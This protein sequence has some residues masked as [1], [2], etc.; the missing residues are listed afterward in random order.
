MALQ[1][2]D[3][4]LVTIDQDPIYTDKK[5]TFG[6]L[7][8]ELGVQLAVQETTTQNGLVVD[9]TP[10]LMY[11]DG[12]FD[13]DKS[14]GRLSVPVDARGVA[15]VGL[16]DSTNVDS[17]P[18]GNEKS[19]DFYIC[20]EADL[21]ISTSK[22][23]GIQSDGGGVT[24]NPDDQVLTDGGL[25]YY[26]NNGTVT[27]T[28]IK[29]GTNPNIDTGVINIT[30]ENGRVIN[31]VHQPTNIDI[32][33]LNLDGGIYG[34]VDNNTFD[35]DVE[36]AVEVLSVSTDSNTGE[37][38]INF[39]IVSQGQG[40]R[41]KVNDGALNGALAV[42][43]NGDEAS[44]FKVDLVVSGGSV[45]S[46]SSLTLGPGHDEDDEFEIALP[47]N[48]APD[49]AAEFTL[50]LEGEGTVTIQINDKLIKRGDGNWDILTDQLANQAVLTI[51][52]EE[53][54]NGNDLTPALKIKRT[55]GDPRYITLA[56]D[57]V[58][59]SNPGLMPPDLLD[60][61]NNLP[62]PEF[63][64]GGSIVDLETEAEDGIDLMIDGSVYNSK[65]VN[66]VQVED[67]Q[68]TDD[69]DNLL[70]VEL[71]KNVKV[72]VNATQILTLG[73]DSTRIRGTVF[74]ANEE[75]LEGA[76]A[77]SD[78]D[79]GLYYYDRVINAAE[80]GHH[81]MPRNLE[82]LS[83][84]G[85]EFKT[86][87][88]LRLTTTSYQVESGV[89][90]FA[91]LTATLTYQDGT[92]VPT[93]TTYSYHWEGVQYLNDVT[94]DA[95]DTA[96]IRVTG[97][98]FEGPTN[99][100][101]TVTET[102]D[103][104]YQTISESIYL[105]FSDSNIV[106]PTPPTIGGISIIGPSPVYV[107]DV[108]T[109]TVEVSP[110]IGDE[111]VTGTVDQQFA[112]NEGN[113]VTFTQ[114]GMCLMTATVTSESAVPGTKSTAREIEVLEPAP[115]PPVLGDLVIVGPSTI[116]SGEQN[117]TYDYSG[118][119]E[120]IGTT[121]SISNVNGDANDF[122]IDQNGNL[123]A[124]DAGVVTI[125]LE[126]DTTLGP[127]SDTLEIKVVAPPSGNEAWDNDPDEKYRLHVIIT[128]SG[129]MSA[130]KFGSTDL[131]G[132]VWDYFKIYNMSTGAMENSAGSATSK[133]S[134]SVGD[135]F[136]YIAV[137]AGGRLTAANPQ[138][139]GPVIAIGPKTF[140]AAHD[141]DYSTLFQYTQVSDASLLDVS[142]ATNV[143]KM[144]F[145]SYPT[146]ECRIDFT[147]AKITSAVQT[148]AYNNGGFG[149]PLP[150]YI[151]METMDMSE[152]VT[153]QGFLAST[154]FKT[155]MSGG[156]VTLDWDLSN[157]KNMTSMLDKFVA[158]DDT[159]LYFGPK[160]APSVGN[161]TSFRRLAAQSSKFSQNLSDWCVS[162]VQPGTNAVK[163]AFDASAMQFNTAYHPKWG[164]CPDQSF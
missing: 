51:L 105:H 19:G 129:Q 78:S 157:C 77:R 34:L 52:N 133:I 73:G 42:P 84:R 147:G 74:I 59:S 109:Y 2:K 79:T 17:L 33:S 57:N 4:F 80:A 39:K 27:V 86:A 122:S 60:Q 69:D 164:Q 63:I 30:L 49:S 76:F 65:D 118:T 113:I 45:Q 153:V 87:K 7:K 28:G 50:K 141:G 58:D 18:V 66:P 72:S 156:H 159:K 47:Y 116:M 94:K 61:L 44:A 135:E 68:L 139:S 104:E 163:E 83:S 55:G 1:N 158:N 88:R 160:T 124:N 11:P 82:H 125:Q 115:P 22:W 71:I 90:N 132:D 112:T 13:Y 110:E 99:I 32:P 117:Y 26:P 56:I 23:L 92:E 126:L 145:N 149:D 3:L 29:T 10:G 96:T 95:G 31:V 75:E 70:P 37:H 134:V 150:P 144:F 162:S 89:N 93:D 98:D 20:D 155:G 114:A 6:K 64:A 8:Q 127:L 97:D 12:S 35:N 111:V 9:G 120:E 103:E 131:I 91:D 38:V 161:V 100:T 54:A 36:A 81:L 136:M 128:K 151:G 154:T 101:C 137:K 107:G 102:T 67:V 146:P 21:E 85:E 25:G 41:D 123:T 143:D 142:N 40:Y 108:Y 121:W 119:A 24:A 53:D 48:A 62:A 15:Y 148:F 106:P 130:P 140:T 16:I 5:I 138:F 43:V 152:C 46:F 14:S